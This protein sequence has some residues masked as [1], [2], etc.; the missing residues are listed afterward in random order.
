MRHP[1]RRRLTRLDRNLGVA[2]S[3]REPGTYEIED[4]ISPVILV[5]DHEPS[6]RYFYFEQQIDGTAAEEG[7]CVFRCPA[8][9]T[10]SEFRARGGTSNAANGVVFG[11]VDAIQGGVFSAL[12]LVTP[13]PWSHSAPSVLE[14]RADS[15]PTKE[16]LVHSSGGTLPPLE[17][18][19][20]GGIEFP[21][22]LPPVNGPRD[23][24]FESDVTNAEFDI[25]F[26]W[27][28][29]VDPAFQEER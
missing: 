19:A 16:F 17:L 22:L 11:V 2:S 24:V 12:S 9:C 27:R 14:I 1:I 18:T 4:V 28:E 21:V 3:G 29:L 5:D 10:I 23:L 7:M 25:I 6:Y 20:F 15:H 26:S 8:G 13:T